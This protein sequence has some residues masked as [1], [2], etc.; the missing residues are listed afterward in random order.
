MVQD[1]YDYYPGYEVY[2]GSSRRQFHYLEGGTWV[3]RPAPPGVS[4]DVLLASP[5]VRVDF[6]DFPAPHHA[7]IVRQYP[8]NWAPPGSNQGQK[9][10]RNDDKHDKREDN[11]GR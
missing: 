6:H 4:I 3:S 5:S 2:Y 8:R 7:T 11:H 10:N 1:D 9:E